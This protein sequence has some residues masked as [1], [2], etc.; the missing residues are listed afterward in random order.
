[1]TAELKRAAVRWPRVAYAAS[2][3]HSGALYAVI[4]KCGG[5]RLILLIGNIA[6]ISSTS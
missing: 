1:M 6:I 3:T 5:V 2:G 4:K